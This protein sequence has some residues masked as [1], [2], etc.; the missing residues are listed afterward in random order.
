MATQPKKKS[1]TRTP[2]KTAPAAKATPPASPAAAR[3]PRR[4]GSTP[5]PASPA[6]AGPTGARLESHVGAQYM[7]PLLSGGEARGLPGIVVA[8]VAFQRAGLGNPMDDVVVTGHDAPGQVATLEVQAKRTI[9][10]TA[11]DVVF[12]DV[13]AF[14][15]R[16][17][18]KPEF[19]AQ[20]Y[21]LAV[22]IART[23]TK[24]DQHIQEVLKWVREYQDPNEFFRRLNQ[25]RV[26]H[27]A[28]REFVEAFR[29]HMRAVGATHDDRA[30]WRLL[31][32]FQILAFDFEQ[33]GSMC[34]LYARERCAALLAPQEASRAGEL[35][36]ALQQIALETDAAGGDMDVE[37]L[38]R[39]L[40]GQ[41]SFRLSGDRRLH[42]ARERLA[43][44]ADGALAAIGIEVHGVSLDRSQCVADA[45]LALERGRYLEIRGA[46]G[47]GKSGVLKH[48]AQRIAVQ[49]RIVV[50]SP[51]RLP[52]G[53][54][55]KLQ[56]LLG[57]DA[58]ASQFLTDLA[59]DGG[60]TLFIDGIDRF[61]DAD[62]RETVADLI[63][64]SAS[65]H[66][67][68]VVATA[69]L[70]F[71]AEAREWMPRQ[72]VEQLGEAPPLLINELGDDEVVQLRT[73][74]LALAALLRPGHPAERLVR[75]LYRLDRLARLAPADAATPHSEAQMA[76]QWWRSGD[77]VDDAVR[78]DRRRLLRALAVHSL[79]SSAPMDTN[80]TPGAA[81]DELIQ[82]GSLRELTA[83]HVEFAH[84]VLRDWAIG[85]LLY[86]ENGQ[87]DSL[88]FRAPAPMRLVRGLEMV[89]R[90]HA[91]NGSETTTWRALL[92]RASAPDVHGSWRRA[93][94]LA[95]ARSE[96]ARDLLDRC[97]PELAANDA[98]LLAELVR[99]AIAVDWQPAAP[100]WQ[101]LGVDVDKLPHNFIAP[102][103]PAWV[104]LIG[105]SLEQGDEVPHGAV[106]QFA[107]LYGRWCNAFMGQDALSPRLVERLYAWLCEVEAK[108]HPR[109][110]GFSPWHAVK[111]EPGLSMTTAQE[112]DLRTGFLGWCKLCPA[113]A[114]AYLRA[115]A[116]HPHRHVLFR[117]LLP[118]IGTAAQA[119]PKAI[120][121][122]FLDALSEGDEDDRGE[123]RLRDLFSHWDNEYFPA[124]PA[125]R[126]FLDLLWADAEQGLRLVRGVVAH[127]TSRRARGRD[128]GDNHITIPFPDGPR[129]FPW[130]QSY[131][132]ARA[133]DSSVLASA[134]MALEAWAHLRIERGDPVEAVVIDVLGPEGSPA[135][136][137][138]VA[139]D[140]MLSHWP[141]SRH[142]LWP[143]AASADLLALDRERYGFDFV[144][145]RDTVGWVHPEPF[146]LTTLE[147]LRRRSSRR[148]SLDAVLS[149]YG[150]HG[151]PEARSAMQRA[152]RDEAGRIGPPDQESRG[153]ADTR[154]AAMSALNRLDPANYREA[155]G[156]DGRAVIEY[157]VPAL[158]AQ[159][160]S[161]MQARAAQGSAEVALRAQLSQALDQPSCS[162]E[163]L[164]KGLAWATLDALPLAEDD[165]DDKEWADRTRFIVAALLMRDGS[166]ELKA[167]NRVWAHQQLLAATRV[168]PDRGA[169]TKLLPYNPAAIAAVGLLASCRDGAAPEELQWLLDLAVRHDVGMASVLRAEVASGRHVRSEIIRSMARLGLVAAIYALPQRDDDDFRGTAEDYRARHEAREKARKE[170]E[171]TR[172]RRAVELELAWL[173]NSAA[174]PGWPELPASRP[175]RALHRIV[176]GTPKV[177]AKRPPTPARALGLDSR[178]AAAW[179][180]LAADLWGTAQPDLLGSMLRHCWPWTASANGVGGDADEEP[181]EQAYEWNDAYF[182]ASVVAAL[183]T[184]EMGIAEFLL[185]PMEQLPDERFFDAT[186]AALYKL[187]VLWLDR[188]RISPDT[189]VS[190]RTALAKRLVATRAWSRLVAEP[191]TGTEMQLASALA[192]FFMGRHDIGRGPKCYVLP[193]GAARAVVLLPMLTEL[194][195]EAAASTFVA[196]AFLGLLDVEPHASHAEFLARAVA[197]WWRA[198]GANAEFW[199]DHGIGARAC[200]WIDK[201]VVQADLGV[202]VHFGDHLTTMMDTLVRCGIP[203]ATVLEGRIADKYAGRAS[204]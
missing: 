111:D 1:G 166:A 170:T 172:R 136:V 54:W 4:A 110:S 194:A 180:S 126:P 76:W 49:S 195:E 125:R 108:N 159:L 133:Q 43:E 155:S 53:G 16:A 154:F 20:R 22:A 99:T 132:W 151:P 10:F 88:P 150:Y 156:A 196:L 114:E 13:V 121:D 59:G 118:F 181:G 178:A 201:A 175:P 100:M 165:A 120:A 35:W 52:G 65:V 189:V 33:P 82:S 145:A 127:A 84:D 101:A 69:R 200:A 128:A 152:L 55:L 183:S 24:I 160:L 197:A 134:L 29:G 90:L 149:E 36:D 144:N 47:V 167:V 146:G 78:R 169:P 135:A 87:V 164:E 105:W 94:L 11:G 5:A 14:A 46:G 142:F 148:T 70:D 130:R 45:E 15:V 23:S 173:A 203:T 64:A 19:D 187:D 62:Q 116:T 9:E 40:A 191:S 39:R 153:M 26:A 41:R 48:L 124:S 75:N 17:A 117:E 67:F 60:G 174:E 73:A 106:P 123:H 147:S 140:T 89:A 139:V 44:M 204:S 186:G 12:A 103:G 77:G 137:L 131:L 163:L 57:C 96:R 74:D 141:K 72:A 98:A 109:V 182:G 27:R 202:D 85:C 113:L 158:E 51:T 68:R 58:S 115:M 177:A 112:A 38:R 104:N 119:A 50:I 30:V 188:G 81:I 66:G 71:D 97:L 6:A 184:G 162:V 3:R 80:A 92:E 176:L 143:F 179:L 83:V 28:M 168:E 79:T 192:A 138:L 32:R 198:H 193:A 18:Q 25:P 7:L 157:V 61:D 63:R 86:E 91:E 171:D 93:V 122:L 37:A 102:S 95:L 56:A 161:K 199:M 31:R 2:R 21:E 8:R 42:V 190:V 129:S 107:G 34:A 185:R